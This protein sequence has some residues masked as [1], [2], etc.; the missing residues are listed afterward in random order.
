[1]KLTLKLSAVLIVGVLVVLALFLLS[2]FFTFQ[3]YVTLA[4]VIAGAVFSVMVQRLAWNRD[5]SI[6]AIEQVYSPLYGV[7]LEVEKVLDKKEY[8]SWSFGHWA[9][10]VKDYRYFIV[11][12]KFREKLDTFQERV[13]KRSET[14]NRLENIIIPK[15]QYETVKEIFPDK[16]DTREVYLEIGFYHND[17]RLGGTSVPTSFHIKNQTSMESVNN[18]LIKGLFLKK[19]EITKVHTKLIY[20]RADKPPDVFESTNE[21]DN[22]KFWNTCL[23][24]VTL[25]SEYQFLVK[26]EPLL[27]DEA[28]QIKKELIKRMGEP[29][30]LARL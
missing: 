18:N 21:A 29:W 22:A 20:W 24:R 28:R 19:E 30:K 15:I 23:N 27:L 11:E 13:K 3:P 14:I 25:T 9:A 2:W 4:G 5:D 10:C 26:E 16:P 1:M 7:I 8:G 6:K 17:E 12:A